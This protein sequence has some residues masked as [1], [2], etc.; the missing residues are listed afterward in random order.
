MSM[1][2][3]GIDMPRHGQ[4]ERFERHTAQGNPFLLNPE[5]SEES[6]A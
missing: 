1:F 5:E 4:E 3:S 6:D 2:I